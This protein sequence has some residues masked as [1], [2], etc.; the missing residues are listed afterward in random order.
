MAV[1]GLANLAVK[2]RDLEAA[3]A[4]YEAAGAMVTEPVE[5]ENGR[6][7]DV[8]LVTLSLTGGPAGG[9]H[10]RAVQAPVH[11]ERARAPGPRRAKLS[12]ANERNAR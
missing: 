8:E 3:C 11:I 9:S 5:W 10:R 7:A 1:T 2:V 6:R 12:P 4:W